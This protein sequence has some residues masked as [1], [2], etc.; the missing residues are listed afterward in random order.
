MVTKSKA[1]VE[2]SKKS[3]VRHPGMKQSF[4]LLVIDAIVQQNNILL[5]EYYKHPEYNNVLNS[6]NI[7]NANK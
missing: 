6:N 4:K 1:F 7:V 5:Q 2:Y 3:V